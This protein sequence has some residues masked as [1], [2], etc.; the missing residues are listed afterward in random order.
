MIAI[1]TGSTV[2]SKTP[3]RG[4]DRAPHATGSA[5]SIKIGSRSASAT[6]QDK[7]ATKRGIEAS[8]RRP[9]PATSSASIRKQATDSTSN[10]NRRKVIR[11]IAGIGTRRSSHRATQPARCTSVAIASS[12]RK[13]L[14]RRGRAPKTSREG[15]I[16]TRSNSWACSTRISKSRRTTGNPRLVNSQESPID[17]KVLWVGSDD[18]NVQLSTDGGK[19]WHE[20]S[21]A[22]ASAGIHDGSYVARIVASSASRGTA[23]VAFDQHRVGDF[24][25]YIVRTTDF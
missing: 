17:A 20:L 9:T 18:G 19:T 8:T 24:A 12:S 3:T 2:V 10:R 23:Y 16:A 1:R 5:F 14:A 11:R 22:I 21:A 7:P 25:P 15:S 13:T 4:W 6:G